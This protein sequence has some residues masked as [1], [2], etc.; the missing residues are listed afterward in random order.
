MTLSLY[1]KNENDQFIAVSSGDDISSPITT[2]HNG[3]TGDI[4]TMQL[5][6]RNDDATKWFSNIII[7]PIDLVDA[8]PNGDI[9]YSETGWGVKL[10]SGSSEP[11]TGEWEEIIWGEQISMDDIGEDAGADTTT[12]FPFWYYITCPPNEDVSIKTDIVLNV[13]YTENSVI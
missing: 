5:F 1:Y 12:Y 13:S 6:L 11:S 7:K 8:N 10:S 3:K 9:Y 2:I 4:K